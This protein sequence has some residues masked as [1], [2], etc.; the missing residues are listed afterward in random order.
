MADVTVKRLEEFETIFG[1]GFRRVRAGL[2]VSSFGIAVMDLPPGFDRYPE[3]D[4]GHDGQEEV[5]TVLGGQG[6]PDRRGESHELEPGVFARVGPRRAQD[7]HRR[8]GR[9]GAG[10][11]R[12]H[13]G[14]V[15]VPPEY[16]EEGQPDPRSA[17]SQ[18]ALSGTG[19][20]P[21]AAQGAAAPGPSSARHEAL[22]AREPRR[23]GSLRLLARARSA[24]AATSSATAISVAAS[25]RPSP[26]AA[27]APVVERRQ[28]GAADR[29]VGL[30]QPPR[31]A[32]AVGDHDRRARR[33]CRGDLGADP[34][35]RGVGVLG[36][37]RHAF[38]AA[39]RSRRRCRR[40]RR[41][42]RRCV[43]TI[44]T[45]RSARI[46]LAALAQDQLDQAR[47]LAE[48]AGQLPRPCAG[49]DL[50]TA[51]R[52]RPSAFETTFCEITTTSPA[53]SSPPRLAQGAR[54]QLR[55]ARIAGGDLGQ[56]RH[57]DQ[58]DLRGHQPGSLRGGLSARARR[59][60]RGRAAGSR[61]SASASALEVRRACRD[62]GQR[63]EPLDLDRVARPLVARST[64]R[65]QLPG[66]N[67]GPIASGGHSTSALVPV[68]CRS[69]TTATR[70][71]RCASEGR[72]QLGRIEQRAVAGQQDRA[73]RL[74][75]PWPGRSR[76]SPPPSGPGPSGRGGPRAPSAP[77][78]PAPGRCAR[79]AAR[80]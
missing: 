63:V 57:G 58:L 66:P 74:R 24:A 72:V 39:G 73:L 10:D 4:H 19:P 71:G 3:H 18:P 38:V 54:D 31:P 20:R 75:A 32:E 45:P 47:V 5:Y 65:S 21:R 25:S 59:R 55:R 33:R 17:G 79:R 76:A 70:P 64:W 51:S 14:K 50:A 60:W 30:A 22:Q 26:V 49:L 80:R 16:T 43:S 9:A 6:H 42:S 78:S 41:S 44:S 35:R 67:A 1:G 23:P 13:P 52:T 8:R 36:Q 62:P 34:P 77:A 28:P 46:T 68:P 37:Q 61:S 56:A 53:R 48:P 40:W 7:H 69:G 12:A 29:D 27:P 11:R 2:G 15:Y